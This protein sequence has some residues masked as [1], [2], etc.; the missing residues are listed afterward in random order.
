M[1]DLPDDFGNTFADD[2]KVKIIIRGEKKG[3]KEKIE[4]DAIVTFKIVSINKSGFTVN[5]LNSSSIIFFENMPWVYKKNKS[6]KLIYPSIYS[7]EFKCKV[8]DINI[9][10]NHLKLD[11]NIP[12]FT[13]PELIENND[14]Y[15]IIVD[16][17]EKN[18][19]IDIGYHFRW[20]HGSLLGYLHKTEIPDYCPS[21]EYN[22]GEEIK[23]KYILE[24]GYGLLKFG[25]EN[26]V[27]D[28]ILSISEKEA[29]GLLGKIIDVKVIR[30]EDQFSYWYDDK[31]TVNIPISNNRYS[32]YRQTRIMVKNLENNEM[33]K[34]E[35]LEVSYKKKILLLRW[36]YTTKDLMRIIDIIDEKSKNS[37]IKWASNNE[38]D[39]KLGFTSLCKVS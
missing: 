24:K 6:W 7:L 5:I 16:K 29:K 32:M 3:I 27:Q 12:Q 20:K 19:F 8:K 36:K 25:F 30:N 14:Y 37:L 33:I 34:C 18:L 10:N 13:K 28:Q 2:S 1:K 15:G 9:N 23:V 11:G 26:V 31:Y 38:E 21:N 35:V 4:I 17:S 39:I 22:M